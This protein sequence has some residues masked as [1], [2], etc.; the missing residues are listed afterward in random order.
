ML[1]HRPVFNRLNE[2][3]LNANLAP[4]ANPRN[5]AAGTLKLLDPRIV[6]SRSLDCMIYFLLSEDLPHENHYDNLKEASEWGFR[7][8]DSIKLCKNID[9]VLQFISYWESERK[10]LPYDTDG[11]VIKVNSL[12]QQEEL[13]FT[14]KSP[15]W[16]IAYKYKAEEATTRLLIS[17]IPGRTEQEL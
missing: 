5:A 16:A 8:P 3:R 1:C 17:N 14:A 10:N 2:E 11:V 7:V 4:F 6:A 12:S 13:G 9:E 15:R